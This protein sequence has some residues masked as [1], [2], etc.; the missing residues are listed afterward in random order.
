MS[1]E[2]IIELSVDNE[3]QF[4]FYTIVVDAKGRIQE[5]FDEDGY[6]CEI[7][8]KVSAPENFALSAGEAHEE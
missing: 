3:F 2:K 4:A 8:K 6:E 7:V 1:D 5:I